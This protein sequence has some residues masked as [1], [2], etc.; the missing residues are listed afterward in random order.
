MNN[1]FLLFLILNIVVVHTLVHHLKISNDDRDIFKI[2]TFGFVE[3]GI[4]NMTI[5]DFAITKPTKSEKGSSSGP[6][7]I[8]FIMRRAPSE[9]AAQQDLEK[10]WM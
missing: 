6:H 1:I 4:M 10:V 3:G 7:R 5:S 9:S 8:G 2:E